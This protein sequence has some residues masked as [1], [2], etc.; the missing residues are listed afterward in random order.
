MIVT[1]HKTSTLKT[2]RHKIDKNAHSE[3]MSTHCK[4]GI[5][6]MQKVGKTFLPE[7]GVSGPRARKICK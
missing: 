6:Q 1:L 2:Q 7:E 5:Q 3:L 4:L